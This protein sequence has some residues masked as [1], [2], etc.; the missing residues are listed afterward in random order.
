M[1]I[2]PHPPQNK[3]SFKSQKGLN[4]IE[5]LLVTAVV[6]GIAV[7][8]FIIYPRVQASK[9]A[10][11]TANM[12]VGVVAQVKSIWRTGNYRTL[13]NPVAVN[14]GVY[15]ESMIVRSPGVAA[16]SW[17]KWGPVRLQA[18][19]EVGTNMSGLTR[20]FKITA[21]QIPPNVCIKMVPALHTSF[22]RIKV[23]QTVV[24]NTIN[25]F[26]G[27][28]VVSFDEALLTTACNSIKSGVTI[29][30]LTK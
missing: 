10:T 2:N 13:T 20:F 17:S 4:L 11:T 5:L 29:E 6:V 24:K 15:P 30:L 14:A 18:S 3:K 16:D 7:A 1:Q 25:P 26:G 9:D 19:N 23:N 8:A 22:G 27:S 28:S 12:L 21:N